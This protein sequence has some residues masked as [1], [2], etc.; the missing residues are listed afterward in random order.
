[1]IDGC[2]VHWSYRNI[3]AN[4]RH[5]YAVHVYDGTSKWS[6]RNWLAIFEHSMFTC[7]MLSHHTNN[8]CAMLSH[9]TNNF[10]TMYST[11]RYNTCTYNVC[12]FSC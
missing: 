5:A 2:V 11:V 4:S 3:S 6:E 9:H 8:F 1:M 7:A 12:I 10:E